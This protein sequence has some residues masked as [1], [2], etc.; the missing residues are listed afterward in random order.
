MSLEKGVGSGSVNQRNGSADPDPHQQTVPDPQHCRL[1]THTHLEPG[2]HLHLGHEDAAPEPRVHD[3]L[4]EVGAGGLQGGQGGHVQPAHDQADHL[5]RQVQDR[6]PGGGGGRGRSTGG[7]GCG[8][9]FNRVSGSGSRRAKITHK[10]RIFFLKVHVL[11][12]W[13]ASFVS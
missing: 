2:L 7:R 4:A 5:L 1:H 13:M 12:C 3:H 8:S 11:K 9:A 6:A 10:S